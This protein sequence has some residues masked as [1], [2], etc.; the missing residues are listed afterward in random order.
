MIRDECLATIRPIAWVCEVC[1]TNIQS[2]SPRSNPLHNN[3]NLSIFPTQNATT[4][5]NCPRNIEQPQ[6]PRSKTKASRGKRQPN[7]IGRSRQFEGR[8]IEHQP[9]A[10]SNKSRW[11]PR[12]SQIRKSTSVRSIRAQPWRSSRPRPKNLRCTKTTLAE[13]ARHNVTSRCGIL[14]AGKEASY[15]GRPC[16][17]EGGVFELESYGSRSWG[18]SSIGCGGDAEGCESERKQEFEVVR[19]RNMRWFW[20]VAAAI[21]PRRDIINR[22]Q[23]INYSERRSWPRWLSSSSDFPRD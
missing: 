10:R 13:S 19:M 22:I 21:W 3:H 2:I 5:R 12:C 6:D 23:T 7:P 9:S 14:D 4:F 1:I 16:Q 15:V 11:R 8:N 20:V 17:F 18:R